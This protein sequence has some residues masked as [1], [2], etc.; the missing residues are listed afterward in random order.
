MGVAT[1]VAGP[2]LAP[3][4]PE[5]AEIPSSRGYF[6]NMPS[7]ATG[8]WERAPGLP[9]LQPW[10][11]DPIVTKASSE[12]GCQREERGLVSEPAGVQGYWL[13]GG[14]DQVW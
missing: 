10:D 6:G 7:E 14:D 9:R 13:L 4:S 11:T 1:S 2:S 8:C 5:G 12:K 3:L